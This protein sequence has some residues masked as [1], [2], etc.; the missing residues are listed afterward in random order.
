GMRSI[1]D[2]VWGGVY[3]AA[4]GVGWADPIVEKR[5]VQEGYALETFASA[6]ARSGDRTWLAAA[7]KVHEYDARW[8]TAPDGTFYTTQQDDAPQP[9]AGMGSG[10]YHKV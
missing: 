10:R 9:P 2:P 8:M 7:E 4:H 1:I 5:I 3:V 6:Y